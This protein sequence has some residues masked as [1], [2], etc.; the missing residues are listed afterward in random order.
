MRVGFSAFVMQGGRTGVASYIRTLLKWLQ[1]APPADLSLDVLLPRRETSLVPI[2]HPAFTLRPYPDALAQPVVNIAWHNLILPALARR[3]YDLVHIPTYRR[4]PLIKSVPVVATVHDLA[5]L[6]V[7]GKYDAARMFYNRRI[8]PGLIRRADRVIAVSRYTRDDIRRFTNY[9]EDRLSVIYS[10]IDQSLYR[11]IPK[12]E[13]RAALAARHGLNQPYIV[14]VSRLEHPA[15]NHVRLIAAFAR[16]KA[17][18]PGPLQLVL[19]GTDWNGAEVIR[20]AAAASPAAA[21]IRIT[22]FFPLEDLPALYSA[23]ELMAY[24]S[25]FEGFGF[26][27]LEAMAC[28]APVICSNTTSMQEIAGAVAPTFDPAAVPAITAALETALARPW[29]AD[30]AQRAVAYAR[31]FDWAQTARQVL[32]VYRAALSSRRDGG[33]GRRRPGGFPK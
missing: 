4:L 3:R 1:A 2:T 33:Y 24:P 20:A 32:A 21:D 18:H 25:L 9:P 13:A 11:P 12:A 17:A 5:T 15:K 28:G 6:S 29:S 27:I 8:V 14:F 7:A 23:C 10:G 22:G 19:S 31:T 16:Y 30:D 26:P